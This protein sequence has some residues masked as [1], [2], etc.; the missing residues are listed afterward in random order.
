MDRW[1]TADSYESFMGRWSRG[2]A[3]QFVEHLSLV[4][5]LRWLDVGCGTGALL[6]TIIEWARPAYV[7]GVDLSEEFVQAARSRLGGEAEVL[8]ASGD[9]LPFDDGSFDVVVSGLVLN[10]MPDPRRAVA[11]WSRVTRLRGTVA[12]YVWDYAEGMQ[13]LRFFWDAA[14]SLDPGALELDE[15]KRFRESSPDHLA[16]VFRGAG[17]SSVETDSVTVDTVFSSFE[18]FWSPF[19]RGQGPAP[20]YVERLTKDQRERLASRL[21]EALPAGSTG[22]IALA[23]RAWTVKGIVT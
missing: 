12:T 23:A 17:L 4:S 3:R 2:V 9:D 13:F 6:E 19:N 1:D 22:E 7:A 16:S 14:V 11:E 21:E 20:G 18:D 8:Q 5:D 10:F 15:G